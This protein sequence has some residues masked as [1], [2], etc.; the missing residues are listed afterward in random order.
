MPKQLPI[1]SKASLTPIWLHAFV[2]TGYGQGAGQGYGGGRGAA[3]SQNLPSAPGF[4]GSQGQA[5]YEGYGAGG[6]GQDYGMQK[7]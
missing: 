7:A 4:G 2:S 3:S 6:Y 5:G 1:L